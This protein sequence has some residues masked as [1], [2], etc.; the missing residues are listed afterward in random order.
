[1]LTD[2]RRTDRPSQPPPSRRK[3]SSRVRAASI[4]LAP[5]TWAGISRNLRHFSASAVAREGHRGACRGP[6]QA[7]ILSL[8]AP[9][10]RQNRPRRR[11]EPPNGRLK[12]GPKAGPSAK[13]RVPGAGRRLQTAPECHSAPYSSVSGPSM[14]IF[15]STGVHQ[16]NHILSQVHPWGPSW[17]AGGEGGGRR[18]RT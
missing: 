14:V 6:H 2:R 9:W 16:K 10:G 17:L 11:L 3:L 15:W 7:C 12:V 1:M 4:P 5:M 8:Y 13:P 18:R